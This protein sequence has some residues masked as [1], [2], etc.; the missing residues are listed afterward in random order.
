V[1][2]DRRQV[3]MRVEIPSDASGA[4]Y[5]L[6]PHATETRLASIKPNDAWLRVCDALPY[7]G[8]FAIL[9][10]EAIPVVARSLVEGRANDGRRVVAYQGGCASFR[11]RVP[12]ASIVMMAVESTS[13]TL[14][15]EPLLRCDG[16]SPSNSYSRLGTTRLRQFKVDAGTA[17]YWPDRAPAGRVTAD[18][19]VSSPSEHDGRWCFPWSFATGDADAVGEL[20]TLQPP[21]ERAP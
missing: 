17:V 18:A 12:D 8:R 3:S 5:A 16:A 7:G 4:R 21:T 2:R 1:I 13:N 20:C 10:G 19:I 15:S 6:A 14:G 11:L 9:P